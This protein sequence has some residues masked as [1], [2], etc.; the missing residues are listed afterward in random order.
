MFALHTTYLTN[1]RCRHNVG[2]LLGRRRRGVANSKP[3]LGRRL[4]CAE[5]LH[6]APQKKVKNGNVNAAV[7]NQIT[8]TA[9]L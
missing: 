4:M 7:Q 1:M 6:N 5:Y 3:T 8:V 2:L 9:Y